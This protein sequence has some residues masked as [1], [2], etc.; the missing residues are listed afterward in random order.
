MSTGAPAGQGPAMSAGH[1]GGPARPVPR[2]RTL[3]PC[4]PSQTPVLASWRP[5]LRPG[6]TTSGRAQPCARTACISRPHIP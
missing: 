6:H 4:I 1:R 2:S 3:R 5:W